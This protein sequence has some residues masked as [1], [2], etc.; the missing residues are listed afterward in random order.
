MENLRYFKIGLFVIGA[1]IIGIIGLVALGVGTVFQSKNLL[2]TYI[3]ESVQGLDVGSPVK[4]RGV[5]VGKVDEITLTSVEYKSRRQYVLV[6]LDI[7]SNLFPFPISDHD[8]AALRAEL[9]RGF[10][11]R[12]AAQGLTGVAYLEADYLNPLRNPPLEI[13]WRPKHPY[14]PSAQSRITQVSVAV[15]RILNNF[16]QI[17]IPQLTGSVEKSLAA[18]TKLAEG[19]NLEKIG[20]QA[21][22]LLGEIRDTNRQL[23]H[24]VNAPEL[25]QALSDTGS[26]AASARQIL[27]RAEKPLTDM[28]ADL[29]RATDS[30]NRLVTRL[31]SVSADLPQT[32]AQLL[33]TLR[34]LNRLI[35]A[36][37]Q[38][39]Q[40]T[41]E[42]FQ[43]VSESIKEFADESRKY[44]SQVIFG[45]PPPRSEVFSR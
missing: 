32:T 39:I 36:Q 15:E 19:A 5:L 25:K 35:N 43:A 34:Q 31:D 16:E 29:P 6:R 20:I 40:A 33:Q 8:N 13:D 44:P 11:V 45:A 2:E 38:Q 23:S 27:E 12:L 30:I 1:T 9:A 37:Q 21:N 4:F 10:R 28:V 3:E 41:L 17:N 14:I 26:A 7:S 24:L 42:N 18:M 22:A